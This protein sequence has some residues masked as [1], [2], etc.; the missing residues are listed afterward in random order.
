MASASQPIPRD[1]FHVNS[2]PHR[3][4]YLL[5]KYL[6]GRFL[7]SEVCNVDLNVVVIVRLVRAQVEELSDHTWHTS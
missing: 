7:L 6:M 4:R 1:V 2:V 3:G 5:D